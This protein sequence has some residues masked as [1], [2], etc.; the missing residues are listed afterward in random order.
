[1]ARHKT[2]SGAQEKGRHGW[3]RWLKQPGKRVQDGQEQARHSWAGAGIWQRALY[4]H[5]GRVC[6]CTDG[7]GGTG[8][9]AQ[10]GTGGETCMGAGGSQVVGVREKGRPREGGHHTTGEKGN[11][12]GWP[13]YRG[14]TRWAAIPLP[15][16]SDTADMAAFCAAESGGGSAACC[17]CGPPRGRPLAAAAPLPRRCASGLRSGDAASS[18]C[19]KLQRP[20]WL[21]RPRSSAGRPSSVPWADRSA[22]SACASRRGG[23]KAGASAWVQPQAASSPAPH[24]SCKQTG[25]QHPDWRTP[26]A[27]QLPTRFPHSPT[28]RPP[29][30]PQ[31]A[32]PPH[33]TPHQ[34]T[35][36]R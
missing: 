32:R 7:G 9:D 2:G 17:S 33:P 21:T 8:G 18:I 11:S 34:P 12:A 36:T 4:F 1:M 10:Q 28:C 22:R 23:R 13:A 19:L 24:P 26:Q 15:L 27:A 29:P 31:A 14:L 35:P 25:P 30:Q 5:R 20:L 6:F 16:T 3:G